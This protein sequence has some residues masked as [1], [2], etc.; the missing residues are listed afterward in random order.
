MA[1][2]LGI[3]D[4]EFRLRHVANSVQLAEGMA[5][6][7]VDENQIE[8][9]FNNLLLNALH[10]VESNG[11]VNNHQGDIRVFSVPG[12]ITRFTVEFPI[13]NENS[14]ERREHESAQHPGH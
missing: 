6:K 1:G 13:R 14:S 8:Q 5:K 4:S 3:V 10:A 7:M 12:E 2:A 9:V 11:I